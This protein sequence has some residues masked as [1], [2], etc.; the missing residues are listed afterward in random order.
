MER[1][2]E[3]T[4]VET[5]VKNIF[6]EEDEKMVDHLLHKMLGLSDDVELD[7]NLKE[8]PKRF[9]KYWTEMTSGYRIDPKSYL[10][11]N[12]PVDTPNMADDPENFDEE[13]TES[14]YRNGMVIVSCDARSNCCHHLVTMHGRI[15]VAYIPD[16]KVVGLSKIVR[17]VKEY[18]KRLNLQEGWVNNI[19]DAMMEKLSPLGVLIYSDLTHECVAARGISEQTSSTVCTVVRGVFTDSKVK[20]EALSMINSAEIRR[21]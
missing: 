13:H 1:N 21:N 17:M 2:Y 11:K 20:N 4:E 5:K 12:F 16:K 3:I 7:A 18:G 14:L 9:L 8:I 10:D 15:Y 19:A 6:N